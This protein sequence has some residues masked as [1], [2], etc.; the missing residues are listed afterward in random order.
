[1]GGEGGENEIKMLSCKS[2]KGSQKGPY[3]TYLL[4]KRAVLEKL[5]VRWIRRFQKF[6]I[7]QFS[8]V[9]K[10]GNKH[11]SDLQTNDILNSFQK[12]VYL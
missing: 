12:D 1:M 3:N 11:F 8:K 9:K 7:E 5:Y 2:R 6:D 10:I 4:C